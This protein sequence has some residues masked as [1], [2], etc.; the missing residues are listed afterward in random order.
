MKRIIATVATV[1]ALTLTMAPAAQAV[2]RYG[3]RHTSANGWIVW[4]RGDSAW[5][6]S[7]CTWNAGNRSWHVN[8]L[9]KPHQYKWTT[10]DPGSWGDNRPSQLNCTYHRV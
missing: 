2:P 7:R 3:H 8:W 6:R 10:S 4:V 9:L 1:A 5:S